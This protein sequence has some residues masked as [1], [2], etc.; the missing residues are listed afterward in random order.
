MR[1]F[2]A[3]VSTYWPRTKFGRGAGVVFKSQFSTDKLISFHPSFM[4]TRPLVV[5][6]QTQGPKLGWARVVPSHPLPMIL[7]AKPL[8]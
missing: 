3:G 2:S 7:L 8:E 1:L 4:E 5:L 6:Q